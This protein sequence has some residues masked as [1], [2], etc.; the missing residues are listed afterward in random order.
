MAGQD[1]TFFFPEEFL[2]RRGLKRPPRVRPTLSELAYVV[3]GRHKKPTKDIVITGPDGKTPFVVVAD[4]E[5]EAAELEEIALAMHEHKARR[6][7]QG[8]SGGIDFEEIRARRGLPPAR[9]FDAL[10][11][12]AIADRIARHKQNHRTDPFRKPLSWDT[13]VQIVRR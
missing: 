8:I 10:F 7:R 9:A 3:G 12:Q 4:G 11:R 5:T 13:R 1:A 2:V 6:M